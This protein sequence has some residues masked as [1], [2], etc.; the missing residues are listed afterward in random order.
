MA[1]HCCRCLSCPRAESNR[2]EVLEGVPVPQQTPC[3]ET[4]RAQQHLV[5]GQQRREV[6]QL[7]E[8]QRQRLRLLFR[9]VP[10]IVRD[11]S[12]LRQP[13]LLPRIVLRLADELDLG[14]PTG[15]RST[16]TVTPSVSAGA[17][18]RARSKLSA[19]A[20][21]VASYCPPFGRRTRIRLAVSPESLR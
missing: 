7:A 9:Q 13:Q 21:T 2:I 6:D 5:A 16:S 10:P 11:Q 19:T 12:C 17:S 1:H 14:R 15:G 20:A 4:R 8:D 18:N 3:L